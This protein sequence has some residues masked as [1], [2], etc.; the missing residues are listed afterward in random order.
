MKL[1]FVLMM[2]AFASGLAVFGCGASM[3]PNTD[4]EDTSAN[5]DIITFCEGYRNAVQRRDVGAVLTMV[6]PRYLDD[7]GTPSGDDDLD[8][9]SLRQR[10][11][12]WNEGV[13]DVRYEMRYRRITHQQ[14]R[15]LVDY[16]FTGSFRVATTEGDRWSRRLS[17]NR[18]VL[19]RENGDLRIISGL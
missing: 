9:E 7:N 11:T 13:L 6:S 15:I 19:M 14:E 10:L 3:I 5:R 12:R 1:R 8:F 2:I 17:D 18:L 16:T 4:V